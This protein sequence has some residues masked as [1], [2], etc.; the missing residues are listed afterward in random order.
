LEQDLRRVARLTNEDQMVQDADLMRKY[1]DTLAQWVQYKPG[2]PPQPP[3]ST[4]G[5]A[6]ADSP[7][8]GRDPIPGGVPTIEIR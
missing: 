1:E 3:V 8:R 7:S 5:S 4:P 6:S 2:R